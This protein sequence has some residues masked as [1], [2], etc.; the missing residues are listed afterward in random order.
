MQNER[1][2]CHLNRV[3]RLTA[4]PLQWIVQ[5]KYKN[6]WRSHSYIHSKAVLLRV[7]NE[8]GRKPDKKGRAAIEKLPEEFKTW[9]LEHFPAKKET[10]HA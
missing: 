8:L 1:R 3:T 4:D 7:L 2:V 6:D 5:L 10:H 9:A